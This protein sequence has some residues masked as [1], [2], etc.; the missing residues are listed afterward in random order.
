[1]SASPPLAKYNAKRD[2]T[3]T[4]EPAGEAT[5]PGS[6]LS[7]VIQKHWA[8]RL[9]YDFRLELDGV[10][11]S[12]AVPKGPSLDPKVKRMA[13]HVEDHPVSYGSFEGSIPE[14]QYGAGTVIVWDRGT[15]VPVG[16]PREGLASGKFVFELHGEKLAGLWELVR[17]AKPGDRQ[18]AWLLFKKRDDWAR[19]SDAYDIA[20]E[21]PDSVIAKPLGPASSRKPV[22]DRPPAATADAVS[23][24][25]S[26][27][28]ASAFEAATPKGAVRSARTKATTLPAGA[29]K[30][31]LPATLTPQLAT[32]SKTPPTGDDW[33]V[34]AKFDG[35][36]IL[37][38]IERRSSSC[39]TAAVRTSMRCRTRSTR[40]ATRPSRTSSSTHRT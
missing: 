31:A 32:L 25:A 14:K 33:S 5:R 39:A 26:P 23:A 19:A 16:D 12:W 13:I 21:L 35:Y 4:P 22:A 1:M 10:L 40:P 6:E 34:E 15:W 28:A 3:K 29:I 38:R 18:E 8:T 37:A 17:I 7:Y 24:T 27:A 9:H 30:A 2:F 20:T 11:V 36:R